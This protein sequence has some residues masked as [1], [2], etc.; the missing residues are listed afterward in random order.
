MSGLLKESR[1]LFLINAINCCN[2]LVYKKTAPNADF[3]TFDAVTHPI[4]L[5]NF[6]PV[7]CLQTTEQCLMH[8]HQFSQNQSTSQ[9][10]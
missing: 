7:L 1:F 9:N 8:G 10:K 5:F 6:S 2:F 4:I 3:S